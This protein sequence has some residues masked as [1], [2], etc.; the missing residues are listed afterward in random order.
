MNTKKKIE[1]TTNRPNDGTI[2][3]L[4]NGEI[5]RKISFYSNGTYK[6]DW[7]EIII[8]TLYWTFCLIGVPVLLVL[9]VIEL[10]K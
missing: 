7:F 5:Q 9:G 6:T 4:V 8:M 1:E 3:E 10:T 2:P